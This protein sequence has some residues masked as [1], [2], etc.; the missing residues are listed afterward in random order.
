MQDTYRILYRSGLRLEEA[1]VKLH[2][3]RRQLEQSG[4]IDEVHD[5][6]ISLKFLEATRRG[7]IRP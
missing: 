2:D 4:L 1:L 5:L 3:Q 6:T 7:I